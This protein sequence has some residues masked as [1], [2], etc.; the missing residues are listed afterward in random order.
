MNAFAFLPSWITMIVCELELWFTPYTPTHLLGNIAL[1]ML[2][3]HS[4][5][6]HYGKQY[7][8]YLNTIRR[9]IRTKWRLFDS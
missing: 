5:I 3:S 6:T 2:Q 4:H 1:E 9:A 7:N 8:E